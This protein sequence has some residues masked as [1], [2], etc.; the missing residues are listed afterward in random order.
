MSLS[1]YSRAERWAAPEPARH[2]SRQAGVPSGD[3][4]AYPLGERLT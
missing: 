3:R 1:M 4:P 2:A